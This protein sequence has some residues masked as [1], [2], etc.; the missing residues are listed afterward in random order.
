MDRYTEK[1]SAIVA[2][3]QQKESIERILN[4]ALDDNAAAS[5][6][7]R[8]AILSGL[9]RGFEGKKSFPP[10]MAGFIPALARQL[11]KNTDNKIRALSM[12]LYVYL[13]KKG[14]QPQAGLAERAAGIA[15]DTSLHGA[16]RTDALRVLVTDSS[17]YTFRVLEQ[18]IQPANP[19]SVQLQ[20][21]KTYNRLDPLRAGKFYISVWSGLSPDMREQAIETYYA[22][23][24]AEHILLDAVEQ[25]K[26]MAS[27][28]NWQRSVWLMNEDDPRVRRRARQLLASAAETDRDAIIKKY[29]PAL[30]QKGDFEKGH[31]LFKANCSSCHQMNGA[32]GVAFGPDLA[33][34]R[35]RDPRFIMADI[36]NPNR[37]IA[38]KY[39]LWSIAM[40]NGERISGI[41]SSE[42]ST[43]LTLTQAG[44]QKI[45]LSRSD[46]RT[47]ESSATSA[48]PAGFENT[49]TVEDMKNLLAFLKGSKG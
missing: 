13:V 38:D 4:Y 5:P 39:E 1:A 48:M 36:L 27:H 30:S 6:Q 22:S 49:L 9:L 34:I 12:Q 41:I 32:D 23:P 29:T 47:M 24:A 10:S 33:S 31:E 8:A 44:G 28:I 35:N 11:E 16:F 26:V 7:I 25:K 2:L 42:T 37:S 40:H 43:S 46:I 18:M 19:Q 17:E 20:A 14:L 45:T 15:L 21:V 3:S